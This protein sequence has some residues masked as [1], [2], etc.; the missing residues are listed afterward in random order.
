MIKKTCSDGLITILYAKKIN[1][2]RPASPSSPS[3]GRK[4][5]KTIVAVNDKIKLPAA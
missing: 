3:N 2:T 4:Q 1:S 5:E